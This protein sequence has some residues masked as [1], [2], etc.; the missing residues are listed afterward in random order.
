MV[1]SSTLDELPNEYLANKARGCLLGGAL[2]DSLGSPVEF[3]KLGEIRAKYGSEGISELDES[4]GVLGAIT[5]DTQ[6]TLFSA[7]G[8]I[9]SKVRVAHRGVCHPPTVVGYAYQRWL[10][11]QHLRCDPM[12]IEPAVRGWL[13][14]VKE[15]HH[16]RAPGN[17]CLSALK[18]W[19]QN[20][21]K[22]DS[23][24]C[25]TV[26]RSAPFAFT[27]SPWETAY[28]CAAITHG[29]IEAKVS[30]AILAMT[31]QGVVFGRPLLESLHSA[32]ALDTEKSLS[33][34]LILKAIELARGNIATDEAIRLL[35]LGWVAEEALAIAVFCA[36]KADGDFVKGVRLA[37][38]HDGDSDS[39]GAIC[40]NILGAILGV[41]GLPPRWLDLLEL[42][43]VIEQVAT[44]LVA[45]V[46]M[47]PWEG[48]T[49][50]ETLA[51]Q[52]F[53]NRYPGC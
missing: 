19:N 24:G 15:L 46:P 16:R 40:G 18:V 25:G 7:E 12:A 28:D 21:A 32:C 10:H 33:V 14:A 31:I 23:K 53:W 35:G 17:T 22:N 36:L 38:N 27:S 45:E 20:P 4:Y 42:R 47:A 51:E 3:L 13:F 9:R 37:V 2:G 52:S 50:E 8:I 6:M 49:D 30:A 39:T 29:H 44:D 34:K 5:D 11:T 26:M 48:A 1:G 43:D 41:E